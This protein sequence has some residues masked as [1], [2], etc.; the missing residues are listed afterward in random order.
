M[1]THELGSLNY[2]SATKTVRA[3]KSLFVKHDCKDA[4]AI[5]TEELKIDSIGASHARK[6]R[7]NLANLHDY[8]NKLISYS[9]RLEEFDHL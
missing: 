1:F 6:L 9:N 8:S 5:V 3:P 7:E 4:S 2:I